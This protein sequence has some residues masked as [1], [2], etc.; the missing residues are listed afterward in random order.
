MSGL[1]YTATEEAVREFFAAQAHAITEIK[2]PKYQDTGRVIGYAHIALNEEAAYNAAL[3]LNGQTM[4]G[5][6]LDIKPAQGSHK[7]DL[8]QSQ[9]KLSQTLPA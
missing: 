3:E 8:K 6:Y 4:G 2:M 9:G 1:P 7:P 5:R